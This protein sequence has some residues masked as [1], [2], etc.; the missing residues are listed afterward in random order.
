MNLSNEHGPPKLSR[1]KSESE[2]GVDPGVSESE[3]TPHGP[4]RLK[5]QRLRSPACGTRG[6][7]LFVHHLSKSP[8]E[9]QIKTVVMGSNIDDEQRM[10]SSE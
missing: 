5:M 4:S 10:T 3:S 1:L 7:F 9:P 2:T 8:A 6:H